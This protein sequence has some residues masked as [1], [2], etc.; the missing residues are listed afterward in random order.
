ML[1]KIK[2]IITSIAAIILITLGII[3]AIQ[4]KKI[5]SLKENLSI[6]HSNE[7]ALLLATDSSKN[8]VRALQLTVDQLNYFND[9]VLTALSNAKKDLKIKDK[10]LK[11]LQYLKTVA[12]K[13]DTL[14]VKDTIFVEDV[15][16]D[17]I[18]QDKWHK[19]QVDL[20]YPGTIIVTPEFT[21]EKTIVVSLKKETID[22]PKKCAFARLFQK[23]H[24]VLTVNI[25]ENNPYID[26]KEYKYIEI[27]K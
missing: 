11:S 19:T 26:T 10:D 12:T 7:K 17:T 3:V 20:C 1:S 2:W 14:I 23:K 5:S 16:L 27:I 13:T 15:C 24:K 22:P 18:I 6:S 25:Q 8:E 21:S 9:S 4:S